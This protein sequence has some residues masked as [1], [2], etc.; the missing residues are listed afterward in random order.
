MSPQVVVHV[1]DPAAPE[2]QRQLHPRTPETTAEILSR[3]LHA[4]EKFEVGGRTWLLIATPGPGWRDLPSSAGLVLLTGLLASGIYLLHLRQ[5]M[6]HSARIAMS[7]RKL[8]IAQQKLTEAHRIAQ[9]GSI[10]HVFGTTQWRVGEDARAMLGLNPTES[11]GELPEILRNV[12]GDDQPHL[13]A[14]LSACERDGAASTVDLE[15][16]VGPL[17]EQRVLHAL[18]RAV[19]SVETGRVRMLVTLQDVTARRQAQEALRRSQE[20]FQLAVRATKDLIWDWDLAAGAM[21]RSE[22]FWQHFG[23]ETRDLEPGKEQWL[24]MLH[25]DDGKRVWN[26]FQAT[27]AQRAD[28]FATE[29]RFRRADGSYAVLLDRD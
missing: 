8:E 2:S 25:P 26:Q 5:R 3:G 13:R 28:S 7:A 22:S 9:L 23:Y 11:K 15:F 6:R 10:E 12:N 27:L 1:I 21:W 20:R 19:A 17:P 18:G 16:R 29:Y 4:E 14:V 24:Q